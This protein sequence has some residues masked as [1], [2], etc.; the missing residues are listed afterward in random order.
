[1]TPADWTPSGILVSGVIASDTQAIG[2]A[3]QALGL[4]RLTNTEALEDLGRRVLAKAGGTW[5]APPQTAASE[6]AHFGASSSDEAM[7]L[8]AELRKIDEQ[9]NNRVWVWSD[10]RHSLLA[11]FWSSAL[12]LDLALVHV[13]R[14]P[15]TSVTA[16]GREQGVPPETALMLWERYN[17]AALVSCA[18][19]PSVI[20]GVSTMEKDPGA[21]VQ[22]L[23]AFLDRLD[24]QPR[25]RDMESALRALKAVPD[26]RLPSSSGIILSTQQETFD[27]ILDGLEGDS[28]SGTEVVQNT[29]AAFGQL[30]DLY[31]AGYYHEHLGGIPYTRSEPHWMRFFGEVADGIIADVAP[32]RCPR[33][34]LRHWPSGRIAEGSRCGCS[35]LRHL[36]MGDRP[37]TG[38]D[39]TILQSGIDSGAD[40]WAL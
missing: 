30:P 19:R 17:R 8:L 29:E 23:A 28:R 35:W 2:D 38:S 16:I 7:H 9:P 18:Q 39:E 12:G 10:P 21:S 6:L 37:G 27:E 33:C 34:R 1:M 40:R 5:E 3:L 11:P 24:D 13:H 26:E 32:R 4:S 36:R 20:V 31:D 25:T 15:R 14:D 22:E